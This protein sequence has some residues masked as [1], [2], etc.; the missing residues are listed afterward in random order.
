[1]PCYCCEDK[2]ELQFE[3]KVGKRRIK[4]ERK[5]LGRWQA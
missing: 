5:I 1:M 2:T 4:K 3:Y